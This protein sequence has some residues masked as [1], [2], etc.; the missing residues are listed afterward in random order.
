MKRELDLVLFGGTGFTG[1]LTA[2]YLARQAPAG[3]TWALAGR[4]RKKLEELRAR[5]AAINTD[6]ADLPLIQADSARP[7]SLRAMAE[8]AAVVATTVGPYARYG[9]PLAA[10]C[11]RAGTH[12]A[13]LTGE[14]AFVARLLEAHHATA[15]RKGARLVNCCGFDSIPHDYGALFTLR[16]LPQGEAV[17]MRGYVRAGGQ[18]S[19]GTWH[20]AINGIAQ[21]KESLAG[22]AALEAAARPRR[23]RVT[24]LPARV[25]KVPS[26]RRW[27]APFPTIDGPVV[28]RSAAGNAEYGP[29]FRYGHFV[30]VRSLGRMALLGAGLGGVALAA[31][32]EP[33][34][35]LLLRLRDPGEGPDEEQRERGWFRVTF[36]ARAAGQTVQC[37]VSG[38]DPGYGDTAKMLAESALCLALDGDRLPDRAG[39]LTPVLAMG[40]ALFPRLDGAGIRFSRD[41]DGH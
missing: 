38:G 14:P 19:G 37:S 30:Q 36:I 41:A 17:A 22:A 1:G 24:A 34:R 9:E 3:F 5:L 26:L 7:K 23:R 40:D 35:R 21:A 29:D 39:V 8:R 27:A 25:H 28:R 2:E 31:Q 32:F 18:L 6:C 4:N 33:S 12:Y 20:S 10:A 13:D 11:A 16:E 15:R